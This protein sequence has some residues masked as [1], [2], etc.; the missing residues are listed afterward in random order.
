MMK[1]LPY[2]DSTISDDGEVECD[3][4]TRIAKVAIVFGC[5]KKP[6]FTNP[7]LSVTVK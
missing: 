4:K 5:L 3:V 7:H 2:L 6:I 1:M